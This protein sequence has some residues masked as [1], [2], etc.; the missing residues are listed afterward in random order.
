MEEWSNDWQMKFNTD[1]CS[2][3]HLG[4]NNMA[5]QYKLDDKK[6]KESKN[7]RDL[8]VIIDKNLKFSDHCNKVANTAN[9]TLGMI[10]RTIKCKS[11]S[12]ITRLYKEL[13]R[14]QL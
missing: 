9:V 14:P 7:E 1:K 10:K 6:L 3:M 8:G 5:N 2:V 11:K 12:I 4:R 13:V